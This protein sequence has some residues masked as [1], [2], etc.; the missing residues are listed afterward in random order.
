MN[1]RYICKQYIINTRIKM[2]LRKNIL[3]LVAC[4]A[5]LAMCASCDKDDNDSSA[6]IFTHRIYLDFVTPEGNN[7]LDANAFADYS[8][9]YKTVQDY[10]CDDRIS[11][12]CRR[13]SDGKTADFIDK[14]NPTLPYSN[15]RV[16]HPAL[17]LVQDMSHYNP[18]QGNGNKGDANLQGYINWKVGTTISLL[19]DDFDAN[20]GKKNYTECY[21]ISIASRAIYGDDQLHQLRL[22]CQVSN[23]RPVITRVE[24]DDDPDNLLDHDPYYRIAQQIGYTQFTNNRAYF[25]IPITIRRG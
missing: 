24:Y 20:A 17:N 8:K 6:N 15:F 4:I 7:L 18:T 2:K 10:F 19:I 23:S 22:Y 3:V 21:E 25:Y 13:K 11:I 12:L 5:T 1:M 9:G 14:G 16:S